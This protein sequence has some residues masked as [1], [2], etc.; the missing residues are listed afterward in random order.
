[1]MLDLLR[2]DAPT[3]LTT[4]ATDLLLAVICMLC[5]RHTMA[6][7]VARPALRI[8]SWAFVL[9]ATA[10]LLGALAHA[11]DLPKWLDGSIWGFIYLALAAGIGAIVLATFE[12]CLP[13]WRAR[14]QPFVWALAL[15]SFGAAMLFPD[16]FA[17]ILVWQGAGVLFAIWAYGWNG[18][19]GDGGR[20]AWVVA[21]L[22]ITAVAA[23][24]QATGSISFTL[25]WPFDHNGVFHLVQI[26]GLIAAA[27]GLAKTRVARGEVANPAQCARRA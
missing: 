7:A 4:A 18:L 20:S 24:V 25:V 6:H 10:A 19:R 3:E 9:S 11:L 5:A 26:P 15:A 1:M 21:G 13:A 2:L 23:V 14:V 12:D 22:V 16:V 8:W 17:V 27:H